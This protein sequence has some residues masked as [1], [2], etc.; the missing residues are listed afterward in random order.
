MTEQSIKRSSL[1]KQI[2][3]RKARK[4]RTNCE[5]QEASLAAAI[6][7]HTSQAS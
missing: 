4:A 3:V 2:I 5:K 1:S 6:W 7:Y